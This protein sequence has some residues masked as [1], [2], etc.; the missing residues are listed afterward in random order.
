M[1]SASTLLAPVAGKSNVIGENELTT[2]AVP[3]VS[4]RGPGTAKQSQFVPLSCSSHTSHLCLTCPSLLTHFHSLL[5]SILTEGRQPP[6]L[7]PTHSKSL[8]VLPMPPL[9]AQRG[10]SVPIKG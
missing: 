9:P 6:H 3:S 7:P 8:P 1:N 4:S 5:T 10:I 2:K